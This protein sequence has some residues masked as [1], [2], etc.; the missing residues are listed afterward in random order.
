MPSRVRKGA[1]RR[2]RSPVRLLAKRESGD[3]RAL[4]SGT[5]GT[6]I[7]CF[8]HHRPF[9]AFVYRGID[10]V[11]EKRTVLTAEA[12]KNIVDQFRLAPG[13]TGSPEVQVA[14]LTRRIEDLGE[15]FKAHRRD[16]H[17]R[18]GLLR[19]VNKR[20][21]LLEYLKTY[22]LQRYR[23]LIAALGLRK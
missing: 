7:N 18:Q 8:R 12:K 20:R 4:P 2:G 19:I 13:D 5:G 3:G 15:H 1:D 22:H 6:R 14:L 23:D 16:H 11:R 10:T 21:K 9:Q 17:S